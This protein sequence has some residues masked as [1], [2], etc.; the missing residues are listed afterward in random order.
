MPEMSSGQK[1]IA[2]VFL[3][4]LLMGIILAFKRHFFHKDSEHNKEMLNS[5]DL[6]LSSCKSHQTPLQRASF[7]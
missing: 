4:T 1:Y 6:V 2:K 7:S 3:K 5:E